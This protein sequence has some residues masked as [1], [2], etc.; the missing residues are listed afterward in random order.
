VLSSEG[1]SFNSLTGAVGQNRT[2]AQS[3]GKANLISLKRALGRIYKIL[4]ARSISQNCLGRGANTK[5]VPALLE[6]IL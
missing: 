5:S 4:Q 3:T 2:T 6:E 1:A